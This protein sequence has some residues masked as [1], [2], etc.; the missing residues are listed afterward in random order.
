[1]R[2]LL[3]LLVLLGLGF[4]G[5]TTVRNIDYQA[6]GA[7]MQGVVV[8]PSQGGKLPGVL[9][10][11]DWMGVTPVAID[12]AKR[13]AGWGYVVF[14]ADVYGKNVRP[15]DAAEAGKISG[16][17]EGNVP[18]LRKRAESALQ[19]LR[20]IGEVDTAR[21]GDMGFCFG[22][23]PALELARAG[24][25]LR[26]V[27][28]IHG[29]VKTP[30]PGDTKNIR[31]KV[32]ILHGGNDPFV[33]PDQVQTFMDQLRQA[34]VDWEAVFYG[35]AVHAFTNPEAGADPSKGVAFNPEAARR[36]FQ[37]LQSFFAET[38]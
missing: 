25:P 33:T 8:A 17:L 27:V 11:P 2:S 7:A 14:V 19:I 10:F 20:G 21:L 4:A 22:A 15:H 24:A 38:L 31:G 18:L 28:S 35:G 26:A 30:F 32:L 12:Y 5:E 23:A 1:M 13:V 29:Y 9:L 16:S 37:N 36:A 3:L 6:D 34:K